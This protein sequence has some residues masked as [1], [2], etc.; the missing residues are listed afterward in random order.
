MTR[1]IEFVKTCVLGGIL[2][3]LPVLL[4]VLLFGELLAIIDALA[5]PLA[6]AFPVE[7]LGGVEIALIIAVLLILTACFLAGLVLS[8]HR[9]R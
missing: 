9:Y 1:A 4:M 2:G 5:I 6:E 3:V 8:N 7:E